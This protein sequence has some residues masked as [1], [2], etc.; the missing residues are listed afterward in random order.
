MW[1]LALEAG[2]ALGLLVFIIWWTMGSARKKDKEREQ[3]RKD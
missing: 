3:S 1:V 2:V